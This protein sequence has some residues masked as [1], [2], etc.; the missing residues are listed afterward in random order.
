MFA[1]GLG[2]DI[3]RGTHRRVS[4]LLKIGQIAPA[5]QPLQ[6]GGGFPKYDLLVLKVFAAVVQIGECATLCSLKCGQL[7]LT[8]LICIFE[9]GVMDKNFGSSG[10]GGLAMT[11]IPF[12]RQRRS[13]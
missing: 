7:L 13:P 10:K 8:D 6:I 5:G 11:R 12:C 2:P 9:S 4:G 3:K 1:E